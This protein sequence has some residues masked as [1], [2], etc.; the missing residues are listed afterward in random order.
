MRKIIFKRGGG[1]GVVAESVNGRLP[2]TLESPRS[3]RPLR[4]LGFSE[5]RVLGAPGSRSSGF[6]ELRVLGYPGSRISGFSELRLADVAKSTFARASQ[7]VLLSQAL[8]AR[9]RGQILIKGRNM[10]LPYKVYVG[11]S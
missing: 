4:V 8:P 2:G 6:S 1:F 10:L 9:R 5:L 3:R 7:S 11:R